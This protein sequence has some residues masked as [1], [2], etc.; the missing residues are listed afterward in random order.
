MMRVIATLIIAL[1][2]LPAPSFGLRLPAS[3]YLTGSAQ[4]VD[5]GSAA[6]VD[7]LTSYT[8]IA[9]CRATAIG[10][11]A[12]AGRI[13]SKEEV[14][15]GNGKN[16][17]HDTGLST[18]DALQFRTNRATTAGI[19]VSAANSVILNEI[20]F[21]AG[22]YDPTDGPRLFKGTLTTPVAEMAY[23]TRTVGVG[24]TFDDSAAN[25]RWGSSHASTASS[26]Q[27]EGQLWAGLYIKER[28]T[29]DKIRRIYLDWEFGELYP[30][31]RVAH[32]FGEQSTARVM[33]RSDFGNHGTVTG[34]VAHGFALPVPYL[35]GLPR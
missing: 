30:N 12:R 20:M 9:W 17:L 1:C 10:G 32:R 24:T 11:G 31:T 19:A 35:T 23:T 27:W 33:D 4:Y 18:T 5:S 21:V 8:V 28:L 7:N 34:A 16:F 2:L 22:T 25:I 6:S 14:A 15:T 29:L 3:L 13:F 26:R